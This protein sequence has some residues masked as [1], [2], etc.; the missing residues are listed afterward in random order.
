MRVGKSKYLIIIFVVNALGMIMELAASRIMSP[1]FGNYN[2]VWTAIIGIILLSGAVGNYIGGRLADKIDLEL[3]VTVSL[4]GATLFSVL[5]PIIGDGVFLALKGYI[6]DLRVGAVIGATVEFF[7]PSMLIGMLTPVIMKIYADRGEAFG[8]SAGKFYAIVTAGGITGTFVGGFFLIPSLGSIRILYMIAAVFGV[9]TFFSAGKAAS[10]VYS[11]LA[12]AMV[13]MSVFGFFRVGVSEARAAKLF[14]LDDSAQIDID[15]H[16][17][18]VRIENGVTVGGERIRTYSQSGAYSSAT[19]LD[20]E[21][22]YELVFKCLDYYN[23]VFRAGVPDD[24]VLMLG[25]AAYM[26]PKYFISHLDGAMDVVEIDGGATEIAKKY[27]FLDDLIEEFETEKN[28]R[29]NLITDDGRIFV[30]DTEKHYNAVFNDAFSGVYPPASL[31]T[32]E[33]CRLVKGVLKDGGVYAL[34]VL[35]AESGPKSQ[36]LKAEV[37][38]LQQVFGHVVVV[39]CED[40]ISDPDNDFHNYM[41]YCSDFPLNVDGEIELDL[42][43]A[44]VLT[45]D[46]APVEAMADAWAAQ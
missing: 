35:G 30:D 18:T 38:T 10:K 41:V 34:N 31:S 28:G 27:F 19:F 36:F 3:L 37:K 8:S 25:G 44:V 40:N 22:K 4:A 11:V 32:I 5:I 42:S 26:Y 1:F 9:M 15:T 23:N 7:I 17:G 45:D 6:P 13:V 24:D 43:D 29:L 20:D 21:K 46:Y 16:Y 33:M 39:R 12:A 14:D 2:S